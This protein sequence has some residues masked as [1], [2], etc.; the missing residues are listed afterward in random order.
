MSKEKLNQAL[1]NFAD[2]SIKIVSEAL[3]EKDAII[4]IWKKR[5]FKLSAKNKQCY[6]C[7]SDKD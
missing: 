4:K 5:T 2:S 1:D 3:A 7:L 6:Y